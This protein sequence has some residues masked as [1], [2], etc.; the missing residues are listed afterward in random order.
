MELKQQL[1]ILSNLKIYFGHQSV[2]R[3]IIEG[4]KDIYTQYPDL[5]SNIIN[6]S[7][8]E[9]N[10]NLDVYF[11][12]SGIGR[13]IDPVSK[14]D[15]FAHIL[16]SK[17]K[18]TLDVAF[19]KLCY[20]DIDKNTNINEVFHYYKMKMDSLKNEFKHTVFIHVTVPLNCR[21]TLKNTVKR[22]LNY[23]Y[24]IDVNNIKINQFNNLLLETYKNEPIFDLARIESTY[25]DGSR[26]TFKS[27][28]ATYY[29]LIKD[30][31]Y[32]YGHLNEL[33]RK[34]VAREL[35]S[36]IAQAIKK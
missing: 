20:I 2:G 35:I 4:I 12:E 3:N 27:D 34:I 8:L 26:E 33:G 28:D 18:D 14:Y 31:T 13:N 1:T 29:S 22:I 7:T 24:D 16:R 6:L 15:D 9:S 36:T 30:Y 5:K 25:P 21:T 32:D 11:S 23:N 10:S 19:L 17:F